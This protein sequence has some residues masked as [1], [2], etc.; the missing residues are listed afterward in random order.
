MSNVSLAIGGR[1]FAVACADGEEQHVVDLGRMIDA[2]VVA[3]GAISQNETRMLLFA[4]LMLADEVHEVRSELEMAQSGHAD[5]EE[6]NGQL[7]ARFDLIARRLE[8]LAQDLE[9]QHLEETPP[10]T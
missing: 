7:Q 8:T 4:A 10:I 1:A 9:Q 2:K 6:T 5:A 3:S